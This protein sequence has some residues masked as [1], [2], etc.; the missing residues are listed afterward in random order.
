M[1]GIVEYLIVIVADDKQDQSYT[2][3]AYAMKGT[4]M[5]FPSRTRKDDEYLDPET[6]IDIKMH[7][8][9]T[10]YGMA[11]VLVSLSRVSNDLGYN[12]TCKAI[13]RI[14]EKMSGRVGRWE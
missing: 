2:S 1:K 10:K 4:Q 8:L 3:D 12:E 5:I 9:I 7:E 14:Y 11:E 13:N 6:S